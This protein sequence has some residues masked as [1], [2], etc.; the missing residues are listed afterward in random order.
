MTIMRPPIL[1][2]IN[3]IT[4]FHS[5]PYVLAEGMS[6]DSNHDVF[7][8]CLSSAMLEKYTNGQQ[9]KKAKRARKSASPASSSIERSAE[10]G[11][12]GTAELAE[13]IEVITMSCPN[14]HPSYPMSDAP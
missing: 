11:E 3:L 8:D 7:R 1:H 9:K 10:S 12:T 5:C 2:L 4:Y 6:E 14:T 13:F